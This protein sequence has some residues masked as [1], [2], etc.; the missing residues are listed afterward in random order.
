MTPD[1]FRNAVPPLMEAC[2]KVIQQYYRQGVT[3]EIKGDASPVTRADKEA[4]LA[5]R[6][7]IQEHYPQHGIMGEEYEGRNPHADWQWVIDPIDGTRN[8]VCGTPL[9]TTLVGLCYQGQPMWGMIYQPILQEC[10]VG[11]RELPATFNGRQVQPRD[12]K[13]LS[14]A[15]I[16]TTAPECLSEHGWQVFQRLSKACAVTSYG[17]DAYGYA[18]LASGYVDI[19]LEDGLKPHDFAAVLAVLQ[20][21]GAHV[22]DWQGREITLQSDGSILAAANQTLHAQ[23]LEYLS[24]GATIA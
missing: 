12:C 24:G 4:E 23:A 21:S 5:I 3:T 9:F 16:S 1:V 6:A 13:S 17:K 8:F 10:W 18:L 14:Q 2:G 7:W 19:V 22:T 15:V 11:G 20:A